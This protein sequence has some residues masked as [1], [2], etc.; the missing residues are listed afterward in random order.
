MCVLR[1]TP[2]EI[3]P[4]EK[5]CGFFLTGHAADA[6]VEPQLLHRVPSEGDD[7]AH[8]SHRG[9]AGQ[10]RPPPRR[11]FRGN[12]LAADDGV[13]LALDL[14]RFDENGRRE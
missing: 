2:L 13:G 6:P 1:T 4:R 12:V 9:F 3:L 10:P 14:R 7:Q 5:K 8:D 11:P